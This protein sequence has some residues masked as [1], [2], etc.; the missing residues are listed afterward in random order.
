MPTREIMNI[1][2]NNLFKSFPSKSSPHAVLRGLSM[3]AHPGEIIAIQGANGVGK[4]TLLK[5]MAGLI[6]PDAG[7]VMMPGRQYTGFVADADRSFYQ[8]LSLRMNI[9]FYGLLFGI[10][11]SIYDQRLAVLAPELGISDYLDTV[12]GH[13]SSGIRQRAALVRALIPDP[14]VLLIDELT[15][16]L[17][18]ESTEMVSLYLR[19][20]TDTQKK[21]MIVVTHDTVWAKHYA[22]RIVRLED[23]ILK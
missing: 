11:R 19:K 2:I 10:S 4:T 21:I 5:I 9:R 3:E 7:E 18:E 8:I 13:C 1:K 12:A 6:V 17:D 22:D 16:S 20:M 14:S 15:R 23:G